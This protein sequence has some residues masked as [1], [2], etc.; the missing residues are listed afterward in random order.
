VRTRDS[1]LVFDVVDCGSH[2]ELN[3]NFED[4]QTYTKDKIFLLIAKYEAQYGKSVKFVSMNETLA[5]GESIL[6]GNYSWDLYENIE[7]P[8]YSEY[9]YDFTYL[10]GYPRRDKLMMLSALHKS[11]LLDRALWSCGSNDSKLELPETPRIID[12]DKAIKGVSDCYEN[13]N[14]DFYKYSRFSVV[15]ETEM[16]STTNRYTEKTY[17]CF[18]MKHPFILAGNYQTLKLLRKDGFRTFH[19]H[20]D[21][22]YDDIEDRDERISA[23]VEQVRILCEMEEEEWNR[24][25]VG[26]QNI[27]DYNYDNANKK[28]MMRNGL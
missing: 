13:I 14:P 2:V 1:G 11:N 18:L 9:K 21:E 7:P 22:S 5:N 19:P 12:Y 10:C 4:T 23:I 26:V 3:S 8:I 25:L 6:Y 16:A 20:I 28:R 17:K 24:F 27:V 15:Q